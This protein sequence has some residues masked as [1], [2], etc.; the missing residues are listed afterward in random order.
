[1]NWPSGFRSAGV[2]AG[3]KSAGLDLGLLVADE[4][5][6]WTGVFTRNAA[7]AAPVQWCRAQLGSPIRAL[8]VNSG[9]ANAATGAQ[10][11]AAVIEAAETTAGIL[12]CLS[13]EI[14][15]SSTGPIGFRLPIERIVSAL[16]LAA[17]G[18]SD[19]PSAFSTSIMTTDTHPKIA[20]ARAGDAT[21]V[22]VAK[23]A[24]MLAPN[25]ATM[26]AFLV[27]DANVSQELLEG[28]LRD[29]VDT[30]FNLISVDACESTND[31]VILMSSGLVSSDASA[32]GPAV[33]SVCRELAEQIV[34][35]AEGASK[36]VRVEV[37]GAISDPESADLGRA[38]AASALWRSA[39]HG[40]DPNWGRVLSALG[41]ADRSLR[42]DE[43]E[44]A[45]GQEV[46]FSKGEPT[47]ALEN[48]AKV[49][50][51]DEFTVYCRVGDGPGKAVV[52]TSDLSPEYVLLNAE[53][54]S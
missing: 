54:T 24:A 15:V 34:R 2:A 11:H 29:S 27:T 35:D 37:S 26:L 46:V 28:S 8:V 7:A 45:I 10:G 13:S 5:V 47:G 48:A 12:G 17:E 21:V 1:M 3:I 52:L 43:V 40:S 50:V 31:S 16:P 30:S 36:F 19:D 6:A 49:M 39:I 9:N 18:L 25:M 22:G 14:L 41:A 23:G 20:S 53:G 32:F 4:P 42:L 33:A 44:I 38:V 51:E